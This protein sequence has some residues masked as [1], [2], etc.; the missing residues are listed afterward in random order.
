MIDNNQVRP[1]FIGDDKA[2]YQSAKDKGMLWDKEDKGRAKFYFRSKSEWWY[3]DIIENI[4][5]QWIESWEFILM[6]RWYITNQK[7]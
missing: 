7:F 6:D 3:G 5:K 2:M 4:K 1:D